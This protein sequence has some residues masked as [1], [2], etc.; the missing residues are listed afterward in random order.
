MFHVI[1]LG[2]KH[3]LITSSRFELWEPPLIKM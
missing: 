3:T 2:E 1:R